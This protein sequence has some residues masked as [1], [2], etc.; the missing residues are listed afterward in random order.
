VPKL[1][2]AQRSLRAVVAANDRW[3][4]TPAAERR[5]RAESGQAGFVAKL[6]KQIDPDGVLPPEELAKRVEN[7]RRAH[8]ARI[9]LKS[10]TKRAR[11]AGDG[12][13]A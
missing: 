7:A 6:E 9:A 5:G 4:R 8:M 3:A 1:T 13:G 11:K 12:D 10:A 2:K